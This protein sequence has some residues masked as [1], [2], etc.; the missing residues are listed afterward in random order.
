M[1]PPL[2]PPLSRGLYNLSSFLLWLKKKMYPLNHYSH[3]LT[4]IYTLLEAIYWLMMT[5]FIQWYNARNQEEIQ[6][7]RYGIYCPPKYNLRGWS[8]QH[9]QNYSGWCHLF[10][11][12]P[13][14]QVKFWFQ[15]L[16]Q[17]WNIRRNNFSLGCRISMVHQNAT[18]STLICT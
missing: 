13:S 8:S 7:K 9:D 18:Q 2:D 11:P 16:E 14:S 4:I 17:V 5:Y 1:D 6:S 15:T 3:R 10:Q 12:S